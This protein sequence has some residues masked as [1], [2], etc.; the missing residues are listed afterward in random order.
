M[1]SLYAPRMRSIPKS[2]IREILKV[3]EDP[4]VISFAG[5]LPNPRFFPV[6]AIAKAASGILSR[7]DTSALQYSTTEGYRPLREYIAQR[8]HQKKGLTISADEILITNGSQQ[9]LD[10]LGKVFIGRGDGIAI[11]R[12]AYLGAIQAFSVYEPQFHMV[13]LLEDGVDV[14]CLKHVLDGHHVK[15]F[16][17]VINFQ[18][19][20]GISTSQSKREEL[21]AL[22]GQYDAAVVEDD[23]YGELRFMGAEPPSLWSR[24][25]GKAVLLGSFSK[26]IAPG[27]RLGWICAK[28][29]IMDQLVVAKQASDLH[30]N[31]LCQRIVHQYL[32]NNDVDQHI[33]TII[34]AY[35]KQR[36]AMVAAIEE[37]FPAEVRFTRPEGGMFLWVT[38]P[39][40]LS[41]LELFEH[42]V[43]ENVA[44][45][46]GT[47]F[48]VDG[49]GAHC[50]RL[51]FSNADEDKIEEGI[52]RLGRIM[53]NLL[54]GDL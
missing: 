50:M 10:L 39:E 54:A 2:F 36:D 5:G 49:G 15:L 41:A 51:N 24:L 31:S 38:L 32:V 21:V 30:S 46:P 8:Y 17:T 47:P 27:L 35:K 33:A 11:E 25:D 28:R 14:D 48:F 3:T 6:E 1:G 53:K 7:V 20:S 42:A 52:K 29:E 40:Q 9:G 45:V 18:N 22:F 37:S 16:H 4:N 34:A 23:P 12:P 13:P 26:T 44:F 43:K 19:P